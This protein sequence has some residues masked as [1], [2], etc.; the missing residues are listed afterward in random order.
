M[1][2]TFGIRTVS[3]PSPGFHSLVNQ[4]LR[5]RF[6]Q[7]G[8]RVIAVLSTRQFDREDL[9]YYRARYY[10]PTQGRFISRDPIGFA[11]GDWNLY[12]YVENDPVNWSDP[13]GLRTKRRCTKNK[14]GKLQDKLKKA[15]GHGARGTGHV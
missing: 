6:Q 13:S 11:A 8:Q 2:R 3:G 7:L 9:Y 15:R 5:T 1:A 4:L 14:I 12:R 10:D